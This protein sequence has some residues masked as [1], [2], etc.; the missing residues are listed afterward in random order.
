MFTKYVNVRENFALKT[1][2]ETMH[3]N[4]N[5]RKNES[6]SKQQKR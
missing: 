5:K 6:K 4:T 3:K 1:R 2:E